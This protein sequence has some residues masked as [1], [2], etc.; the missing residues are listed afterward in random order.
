MSGI[1]STRAQFES[2]PHR[3]GGSV[4]ETRRALPLNMSISSASTS[5]N[6]Q[7]M[8]K[9]ID[10]IHILCWEM[11]M[12]PTLVSKSMSMETIFPVHLG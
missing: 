12:I 3:S 8:E 2:P 9:D 11:I 6:G 5:S 4:L 10:T 7:I 1:S